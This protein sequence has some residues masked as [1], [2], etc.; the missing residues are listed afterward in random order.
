MIVVIDHLRSEFAGSIPANIPYVCWIQDHMDALYTSQAGASVTDLD[1]VIGQS[2]GL[3]SSTYGYPQSRFVASSNLTDPHTYSNELLPETELSSFRCDVSYIGHGSATPEELAREIALE[4]PRS[5][6]EM[7]QRFVQL[8]KAHLKRQGWLT[9]AQRMELS[10][11]AE[12][13]SSQPELSPTLR[14]RFV[15]PAVDRL[16]DRIIRHQ[17]L[18]W[19][20]AWAESKGR[21]FRIFGKGWERHPRFGKVASGEVSNGRQLRA[22]YQASNMSLQVTAY[23]SLHQRL[24]DGLCCGATMVVRFNP[25]D[26]LRRPYRVVNECIES[27]GIRSLSNLLEAAN[28]DPTLAGALR[29][30]ERLGYVRLASMHD[31]ARQAEAELY[32]ECFDS[33]ESSLTDAGLFDSLRTG[34]FIPHRSASDLPGFDEIVFDSP[35]KLHA[36]LSQLVDDEPRRRQIADPMRRSVL[37]H[38]THEV[39]VE[40]L[41]AKFMNPASHQ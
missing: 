5:F 33:E 15:L 29:E 39:L 31:D 32:R 22:A 27:Q 17:T 25:F 40:K 19:A 34:R 23:A 9:F 35:D 37:T 20:A 7:L 6:S 26:F 41:I 18:E 8:A 24:L 3:M 36:L 1:V 13:E 38:D 16:F 28:G 11:A 2:P 30:L 12:R 21:R 4:S 10:L 14:R